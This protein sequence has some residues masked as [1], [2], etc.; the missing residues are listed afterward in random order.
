M[1]KNIIFDMDGV[2]LDSESGIRT[3]CIEML[4]TYGVHAVPEDFIPFTGMGEVRFIGGVAAKYG[5][6]FQPQMQET[7]YDI[8]D[9]DA[10]KLV[11]IY[12]GVKDLVLTLRQKGYKVAV[13]SSAGKRKVLINLRC[14]GVTREDFDALITGSDVRNN[15]PDPEIFLAAAAKIGAKPE[16]T[17]VIEDA[18]TGIQAGLAA[19]MRCIGV[20]ST[21]DSGQLRNAGASWIVEKTVDILPILETL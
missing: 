12:E 8:Y 13:A 17:L 2:L 5:M 19:G 3:A 1:I 7:A 9:Q 14:I 10:E 15:K 18:V 16:E 20:T 6:E 4:K 21:F 11:L